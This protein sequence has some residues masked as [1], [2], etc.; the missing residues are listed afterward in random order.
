MAPLA[1]SA[2]VGLSWQ[3]A[4][5]NVN[6]PED[7]SRALGNAQEC[8][9][10]RPMVCEFE[11]VCSQVCPSGRPDS[12]APSAYSSWP[13]EM[14]EQALFKQVPRPSRGLFHRIEYSHQLCLAGIFIKEVK[15]AKKLTFEKVLSLTQTRLGTEPVFGSRLKLLSSSEDPNF[16]VSDLWFFSPLTFI[17]Y[18]FSFFLPFWEAK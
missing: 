11:V 8:S 9:Q 12:G 2:D 17:S 15:L 6:L 13:G 18:S 16:A 5:G 1:E 14:G 4:V 10:W 3:P 7:G